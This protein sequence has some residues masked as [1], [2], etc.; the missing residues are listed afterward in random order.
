MRIT[1][2]LN[3]SRIRCHYDTLSKRL[4]GTLCYTNDHGFATD[5]S[6]WF[7]RQSSRA[8]SGWYDYQEFW[9]LMS[10][11]AKREEVNTLKNFIGTQSARFIHQHDR[12]IITNGVSQA[13]SFANEFM[14]S[15][16]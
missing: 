7:A 1:G 10:A 14:F 2:R 3:L 13:V 9:S 12:N 16:I 8:Q 15:G 5:I 6:Q 11:H 4:F